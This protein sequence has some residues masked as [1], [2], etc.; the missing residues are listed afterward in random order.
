MASTWSYKEN[1]EGQMRATD[2]ISWGE[3]VDFF[4]VYDTGKAQP[5]KKTAKIVNYQGVSDGKDY[6]FWRYDA[7]DGDAYLLQWAVADD[8][9]P[10]AVFAENVVLYTKAALDA[11]DTRGRKI[12][13]Y[14]I[15]ALHDTE[16]DNGFDC[17]SASIP[18]QFSV[19]RMFIKEDMITQRPLDVQA[20]QL[21]QKAL[22]TENE[23]VKEELLS[24]AEDLGGIFYELVFDALWQLRNPGGYRDDD[25]NPY[26]RPQGYRSDDE[27]EEDD[28]A[29]G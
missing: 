11:V 21:Y 8:A 4:V 9:V 29:V 26:Y 27:E 25:D 13:Q 6:V 2:P 20:L 24:N 28:G 1:A 15:V 17:V 18:N 14:T 3:G 19:D 5:E 12:P 22:A 16:W 7:K 10:A 23:T